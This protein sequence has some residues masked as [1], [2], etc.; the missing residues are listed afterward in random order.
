M[1]YNLRIGK[2]RFT[3]KTLAE[4][5]D[6]IAARSDKINAANRT[7]ADVVLYD[8]RNMGGKYSR[9]AYYGHDGK[10][11]ISINKVKGA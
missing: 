5:C 9:M 7:L 2:S 6:I 1:L 11:F 8:V 10:I 4:C 3:D